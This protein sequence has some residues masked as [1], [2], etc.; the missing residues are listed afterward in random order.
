MYVCCAVL[1]VCAWCFLMFVC[2][3]S[4][5]HKKL[6]FYRAL[7]R[8]SNLTNV[9]TTHNLYTNFFLPFS[10]FV[11]FAIYNLDL[12]MVKSLSSHSAYASSPMPNTCWHSYLT[13]IS[14]CG[15][16]LWTT[17]SIRVKSDVTCSIHSRSCPNASPCWLSCPR[18]N[19]PPVWFG[20]WNRFIMCRS[21]CWSRMPPIR[22]WSVRISS[23]IDILI[24][25]IGGDVLVVWCDVKICVNFF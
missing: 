23:C 9:L 5:Y 6:Q 20:T 25:L 14:A 4:L 10:S 13:R 12:A 18:R 7:G 21:R 15:N 1:C 3:I 19:Y 2:V 8:K 22:N 16:R 24:F 11:S 17:F